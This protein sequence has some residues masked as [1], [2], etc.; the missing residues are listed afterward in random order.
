LGGRLGSESVI[1]KEIG[2]NFIWMEVEHETDFGFTSVL[3]GV[4]LAL[5]LLSDGSFAE[6][7]VK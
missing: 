6:L 5:E 7:C 2:A 4:E 1:S 3:H